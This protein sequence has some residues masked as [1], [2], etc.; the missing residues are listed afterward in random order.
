MNFAHHSILN[1]KRFLSKGN[2]SKAEMCYP[3]TARRKE[4]EQEEKKKI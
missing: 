4:K 1:R 2:W 3:Q